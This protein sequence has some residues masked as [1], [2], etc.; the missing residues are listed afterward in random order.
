[1]EESSIAGFS[2]ATTAAWVLSSAAL[3]EMECSWET[4]RN[5]PCYQTALP[6]ITAI[7]KGEY[8]RKQLLDGD[9]PYADHRVPHLEP[10]HAD[11]AAVVQRRVLHC[12]IIDAVVSDI[13]LRYVL[14]PLMCMV[15]KSRK[16]VALY[17]KLCLH[18]LFHKNTAGLFESGVF[19][20]FR[21]TA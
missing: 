12:S 1:M 21:T 18:A 10:R 4:A 2:S 15:R 9:S 14:L 5:T 8:Q 17:Y 3:Q 20:V 13:I 6:K 19:A 11:G 7:R 16:R